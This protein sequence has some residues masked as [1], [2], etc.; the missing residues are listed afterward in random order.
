MKRLAVVVMALAVTVSCGGSTTDDGEP[1]PPTST[2][3]KDLVIAVGGPFS[4]AQKTVGDQMKAGAR[5]AA[6]QVNGAGGISA[7][8]LR[9]SRIVIDDSFDDANITER[10]VE[11]IRRVVDDERYVAF[12]GSG[13]SDAS[14]AAAPVASLAG[15]SYLAAQASSPKILDAATIQECVFVLPPTSPA[16]AY[17]VADELVATGHSKPAILYMTGTDGDA[18]A[19]SFAARLKEKNLEPVATESFTAGETDFTTQL[20]S[21][22]ALSP[23]SLVVVGLAD[24][25]A[26]I[27]EQAEKLRLEVPVFDPVGVTADESFL[28]A[29]GTLASGVI[30]TTP[31]DTERN[32]P[33][34]VALREAYTTATGEAAVPAP[35]VFA[36]E[37]VQAVA[38]GF[39]DGAATR[40]DLSDHL[41]AIE[42]AD[43]GSGPLSF[44]PD[45]SRLGGRV[46]VFQIVA[47]SP[48]F[49]TAYE[50][51]GPTVVEKIKLER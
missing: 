42:I 39:A 21:I 1:G 10:A 4:G 7:G 9:G 20:G 16:S 37:G 40:L 23:D 38:A 29:A 19:G 25:D 32:R 49:T 26:L 31:A 12:V 41:H 13:L 48:V 44:G 2:G 36:Y 8:P 14:V 43:A 27:L 11:N 51:T 5:L 24:S 50:Q 34:A 3:P 33:A 46:Y 22:K 15:L 35:A 6:E 28:K 30:G 17:A 47:G 18:I 45:G